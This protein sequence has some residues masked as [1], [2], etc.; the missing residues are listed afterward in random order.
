[1]EALIMCWGGEQVGR[2]Q[3]GGTGIPSHIPLKARRPESEGGGEE[4]DGE[5]LGASERQDP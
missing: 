5:R 3:A 4:A 1:M 2:W